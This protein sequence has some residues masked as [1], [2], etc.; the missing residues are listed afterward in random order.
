MNCPK[1]KGTGYMPYLK[2]GK[3][4]P[5]IRVYC[6]CH[7][8]EPEHYHPVSVDDFDFPCSDT[9]RGYY[10]QY[11]GVPDPGYIPPQPELP[12]P[13]PQEVIHRHSDI[14]KQEYD[15]LQQTARRV[16]YL[17]KLLAERQKPR[18]QAQAKVGYKGIK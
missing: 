13:K 6:E 5:G 17:E 12:E 7:Q 15:L 11:C 8:D 1:C 18:I 3:V 2:N 14:S 16:S 9:F 4:I 10:H